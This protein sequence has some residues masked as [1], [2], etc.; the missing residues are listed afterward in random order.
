MLE[1]NLLPTQIQLI[2]SSHSRADSDGYQRWMWR[3][4]MGVS[5]CRAL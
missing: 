1:I 4:A 5:F 2:A 3:L